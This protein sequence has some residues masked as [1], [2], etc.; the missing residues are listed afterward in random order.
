MRTRLI[1]RPALLIGLALAFGS[2][3][4]LHALVA[5]AQAAAAP[6]LAPT[7]PR[8][9]SAGDSHVELFQ[10]QIEKWDGNQ[11]SG[12]A[13]LA[14][15]SKKG[16]PLYG[17][18]HFRAHAAIDKPGGIVTL[19]GIVI[20]DVQIPTAQDRAAGYR[21]MLQQRLPTGGMS[22]PLDELQTSYLVSQQIGKAG[23]VAVRNDPPHIMFASTPTL[24]VRI[25]GA[26]VLRPVSG[27]SGWQR[28]INTRALL[29]RDASERYHL[30]AAGSWYEAPALNGS[31]V[32]TGKPATNLL[33]AA[34]AA[35][36]A[37]KPDPMLPTSGKKPATAPAVLIAT[38]PTELVVT[39]GQPAMQPVD[40]VN[41]LTV[42]NADHALF[43]DPASNDYYLL[44]SGRWFAG[45]DLAGPWH[46]VAG[47]A[48][49][50]DFARIP[51]GSPKANV[52]V[53]VP[54]TPQAR[55]AVIAAAIPQTATVYRNKAS[56][57]VS[58]DGAPHFIP[59]AGTT[60][61]YAPNSALPVIEV[62]SRHY[63]ALSSGIWFTAA[64]PTGAWRVADSV[65]GAIYT[66]PVSSPLHYVTYV[67]V[68][69][70]TPQYVVVGYTPGY[71]GVMVAPGGTVVY[72]SGYS[73]A[74][75][76]GEVWYGYPDTY[77]YGAGFAVGTTVGFAF[78]FAA[79]AWWGA[80]SPYWGPYWGWWGGGYPSWQYVNVN[81]TNIYGRWGQGTVTHVD[82]WNG[83]TGNQ[84]HGTAAAGFNPYTGSHFQAS[85]GAIG[86][87]YTGNYAAGRQGSFSSPATGR[88]GA[89]RQGIAGN[90][91]TGNYAGGSQAAGV[92]RRTGRFGAEQTTVTGNTASGDRTVN[93]KGFVGNRRTDS[94]VAWNNGEI[95]AGHDNNVYRRSPDGSWEQHTP[96]GWQPVPA[97]NRETS[98]LNSEHQARQAGNQRL[99]QAPAR[100]YFQPP[101]GGA[102]P[103][104]G[105]S[106]PASGFFPRAGGGFHGGFRR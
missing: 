57:A 91:A 77:G 87:A 85:R 41:L 98:R 1:N 36:K 71:F 100:Q 54:G 56:L 97:G 52:L 99:Q 73:Y 75:Y 82:G 65:P 31:W 16:A 102:R 88:A 9:L 95:Y 24:L 45:R 84:W 106:R 47:S 74:P 101:E 18:A 72:G 104:Q 4:P 17:I 33:A 66:I 50:A 64:T 61:H 69:S 60:L 76:T 51:A 70:H 40:G 103:G 19:T 35:A 23:S 22:I 48:L 90:A 92:N 26:P 96:D 105:A 21:T 20:D 93:S 6:T 29:L 55:E 86:N 11:L 2:I 39:D 43:L 53:S 38:E 42:G 37:V 83:W 30:N 34:Q 7:W 68:Y 5:P 62:D 13:A 78:G 10:P 80:P 27:A 67:H 63:Y 15:S 81:Q 79:G 94:G 49:P 12:R 25:D 46:A 28:V 89:G 44:I 59:I 14:I 32:V 58:Y 8:T 3:L